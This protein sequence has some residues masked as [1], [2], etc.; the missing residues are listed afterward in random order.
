[1]FES[2]S[3]GNDELLEDLEFFK[4][5]DLPDEPQQDGD[6]AE[7]PQFEVWAENW[8]TLRLFLRLRTQWYVVATPDGEIVRTGLRRDAIEFELRHANGIPKRSWSKV[9]DQIYAM[10][11]AALAEFGKNLDARRAVRIQ[12]LK[13]ERNQ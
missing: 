13:R 11:S 9:L 5:P 12:E 7:P 10:E 3:V 2:L 1:V 8:P 6:A 4:S